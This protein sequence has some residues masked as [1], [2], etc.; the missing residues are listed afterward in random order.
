MYGAII[1]DIVGSVYEFNNIKTKDFSL[2]SKSST[3]TDDTIMTVA[4]ARALLKAKNERFSFKH[5][6]I[7]EMR[8]M[9]RRFPNPTG[10][11]GG[12]FA[13]WLNSSKPKPYNSFGNGSAMRVSPCGLIAIDLNEALDLAKASAEVTHNHPEGIKGAQAV[14]GA[15]FLAKIGLS[16]EIIKTTAQE[17]YPLDKS[18]EEIRSE[19]NFDESCQNT[20]PQAITAFLESTDFDDAIRNAVSIGGDSD[21]IAAITG[22]IAWAFY[23]HPKNLIPEDVRINYASRGYELPIKME[24]DKVNAN[25]LL[26]DD[27]IQTIELF[28]KCCIDRLPCSYDKDG[29]SSS[30]PVDKWT[31]VFDNDHTPLALYEKMPFLERLKDCYSDVHNNFGKHGVGY[32]FKYGLIVVNYKDYFNLFFDKI[33]YGTL[34]TE[35]LSLEECFICLSIL[36][37]S[38]HWEGGG[39]LERHH[40]KIDKLVGRI[41]EIF[42]AVE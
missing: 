25:E 14:A 26:P 8:N 3:F 36:Q 11:Y 7:N 24:Q 6:L 23:R 22:S 40:D 13:R 21:T 17:F 5:H 12:N 4:V 30:I 27:F 9:G 34:S 38:D 41:I 20:V 42:N 19:Y 2:F 35:N 16:K 37:R 10:G 29:F 33:F 28:E 15:V 1:G 39:T 31:S 18:L 32:L